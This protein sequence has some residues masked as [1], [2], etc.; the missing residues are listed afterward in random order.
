[1]LRR[2]LA[3]LAIAALA[4]VLAGVAVGRTSATPKLQGTVGPGYTISLKRGTK[5]VTKLKAGRYAFAI[6]DKASI[7]SF[8]IE[9]QTG[10]KFEKTLSSVS[11]VG[12]KTVTVTLKKGKWKFYCK[13]HES[14]MFGFFTVT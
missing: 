12:K 3:I 5:K 13:P 6:S 8:V 10:G 7:H 2:S 11:F 4:A 9:Q 14:I 1:V